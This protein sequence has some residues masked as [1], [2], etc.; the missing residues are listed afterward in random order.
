[1]ALKGRQAPKAID[2]PY[3]NKKSRP[4]G[5][6]FCGSVYQPAT[7][8]S[9]G[10]TDAHEPQSMQ[11]SG[12]IQRALSFSLIALTG[13]SLSLVPQSVQASVTLYAMLNLL[14]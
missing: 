10:H 13:H 8:A 4:S 11:V 5:R 3:P 9:T 7:M 12:S 1:M 2:R 14:V 6:P